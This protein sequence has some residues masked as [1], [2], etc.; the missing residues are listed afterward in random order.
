MRIEMA[1]ALGMALGVSLTLAVFFITLLWY[2][3]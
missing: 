3:N 2:R 1:F